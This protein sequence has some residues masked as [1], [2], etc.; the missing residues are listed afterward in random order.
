MHIL[1]QMGNIKIINNIKKYTSA[2]ESA[3]DRALNRMSIDIERL[4]KEQVPH[5]ETGSLKASGHHERVSKLKYHII[6]NKV[7]ALYQHEGG[8]GKRVVRRYSKP[9]KKKHYLKDPG[10][11]IG[12]KAIE[13]FR[14]EVSNIRI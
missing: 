8:D 10:E 14:Q 12:R 13:Y 3:L 7:Y 9:G 6:Y 1:Y 5:G 4:S 2:N 11:L